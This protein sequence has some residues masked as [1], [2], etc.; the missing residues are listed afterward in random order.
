VFWAFLVANFLDDYAFALFEVGSLT[1]WAHLEVTIVFIDALAF[2]MVEV[3]STTALFLKAHAFT[4]VLIN[5]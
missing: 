2:I 1:V 4:S 3:L 5:D